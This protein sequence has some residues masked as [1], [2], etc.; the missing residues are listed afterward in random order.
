MA[1]L[2]HRTREVQF[3]I[4]YCGTPQGGK[5]SNLQHVHQRLGPSHRG[6][7]ISIAGASDR[8]LFFDFLPVNAHV[9]AGFR[10][11]FQLYTV[12]GQRAFN[13]TRQVVLTGVD[14]VVFVADSSPDRAQANIVALEATWQ[15]LGGL[16][17]KPGSLPFVFQYNKR[18]LPNALPCFQLQES[19]NPR[20]YP[21]F[22]SAA[23]TG[24]NVF[25]TL[26]AVTQAVL[27]GFHHGANRPSARNSG[28]ANTPPANGVALAS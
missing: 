18:D 11:R 8:T 20:G 13:E 4:V 7:L 15:A 25:T 23:S 28:S 17:L 6:D 2:N 24:Y 16:G 1:T 9:I 22:A 14:G 19:L 10:T 27:Q 26:E 3:K 21:S 5:T 12:P